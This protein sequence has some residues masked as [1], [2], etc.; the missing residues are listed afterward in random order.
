MWY[1]IRAGPLPWRIHLSR[2]VFLTTA[3]GDI[4][5]ASV[6]SSKMEMIVVLSE[7]HCEDYVR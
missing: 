1:N 4:L 5:C 7:D 6:S 2:H 3:W